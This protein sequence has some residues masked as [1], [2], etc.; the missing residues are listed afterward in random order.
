MANKLLAVL[1]SGVNQYLT[2]ALSF[3][4]VATDL[5]TPGVVGAFTA[6][7]GSFAVT[8]A[9]VANMTAVVKGGS[10]TAAYVSATPTGGVAQ[11]FGVTLDADEAV[12]ISNNTSGST[13]YDFIYI[14]LDA[15]KLNNPAVNGLDVVTLVTVRSS[16]PYSAT[17]ANFGQSQ[18]AQANTLL[19]GVATVVNNA[20][21]V[22]TAQI[23]DARVRAGAYTNPTLTSNSIKFSVYRNAALTPASGGVI[24][25]DTKEFDTGNNV[26]IVTNKG[27]FTAPV[28][29]FYQFS[30]QGHYTSTGSIQNFSVSIN[31]NGAVAKYGSA[32]VSMYA[33]ATS[34]VRCNVHTILSLAA[35]DYVEAAVFTDGTEAMA[36]GT[37]TDN[38]FQGYLIS[39]T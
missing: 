1:P 14:K 4:R 15:T 31:K 34:T 27:R 25:C 20:V 30:A 37:T 39:A 29:G 8:Q 17:G 2:P 5:I 24:T 6:T 12:T 36:V 10:I 11:T 35:G 26:D 28:A 22:T 13:V 19:I 23:T 33:G 7:T 38:Y 9:G 18:G 32:F 3:N 21:S 16:T